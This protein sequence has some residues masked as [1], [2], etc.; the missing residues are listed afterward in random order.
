MAEKSMDELVAIM[1][2][3]KLVDVGIKDYG[4]MS[5]IIVT[6]QLRALLERRSPEEGDGQ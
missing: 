3:G 6:D 1:E 4:S 2:D 5:V